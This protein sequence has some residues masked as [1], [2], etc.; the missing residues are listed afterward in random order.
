MRQILPRTTP[1]ISAIV[2]KIAL[3]PLLLLLLLSTICSCA[4]EP[5]P[6]LRIGTNIWVG[7][8][9]L[10]LARELGYF[11]NTRIGLVEYTSS[12][13]S[14]RSMQNGTIDGAALTLD[15]V[16]QLLESGLELKVVLVMDVSHGGDA[17]LARP[18]IPDL[19]GL[20]GRR[21]GYESTPLGAFMLTR[22][23]QSAGMTAADIKPVVLD[24]SSHES[25]FI[26]GH[27]DAVVAYD[28]VRSRLLSAGAHTLFD[29]SQIPDEI[30]DVLV[31]Q[32]QI[33]RQK[34][35]QVEK[36]LESW[37]RALES[38]ENEPSAAAKIMS[39]RSQQSAEAFLSSL[40]G[41]RFPDLAANHRLLG[42][43]VPAL[44]M[45]AQ[46]LEQ[47]E[48]ASRFLLSSHDLDFLFDDS[49]LQGQSR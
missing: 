27:I 15:E 38:L 2:R 25:E 9:P 33:A 6:P 7:Y 28:P 43:K 4:Q 5:Q 49:F 47:V 11:D 42:G 32:G 34:P 36:L 29:S 12:S 30:V 41:L 17:I 14:M 16:L 3:C 37:F 48:I 22:A 26:K 21:V 18:D 10:F 44:L 23:L 8:E 24:V 1:V 40:S 45:T 46:Q 31:V 19:A 35:R 20:K 13:E 39:K